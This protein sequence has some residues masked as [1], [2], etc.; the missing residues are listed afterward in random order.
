MH[1]NT[2]THPCAHMC[3]PL[4][5]L[6]LHAVLHWN[7]KSD[8][9][10][11]ITALRAETLLCFALLHSQ[12]TLTGGFPW[13][14]YLPLNHHGVNDELLL[15]LKVSLSTFKQTTRWPHV[16]NTAGSKAA[17]KHAASSWIKGRGCVFVET[18]SKQ[19]VH[20]P[21]IPWSLLLPVQTSRWQHHVVGGAHENKSYL[22]T[23]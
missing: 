14:C 23:S 16:V 7:M 9:Y 22:L 8:K 10:P 5:M 4:F 6:L 1:T 12:V 21:V 3:F 17:V 19:Q 18:E 2:C 13:H 11:K 20:T 15:S